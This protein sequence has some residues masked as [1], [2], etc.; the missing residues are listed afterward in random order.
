MVL[1]SCLL[2]AGLRASPSEGV[3]GG[4]WVVIPRNLQ[5]W[6]AMISNTGSGLVATRL[7]RIPVR[8]IRCCKG[9]GLGLVA[10]KIGLS[11]I[12]CCNYV[13]KYNMDP[14]LKA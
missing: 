2:V 5:V 1:R 6:G 12:S 10:T 13:Q 3:L 11:G 8:F 4:S 14:E 9:F 7:G